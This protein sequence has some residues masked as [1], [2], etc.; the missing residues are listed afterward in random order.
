MPVLS[1]WWLAKDRADRG[2]SCRRLPRR[3]PAR[4]VDDATR[5]LLGAGPDLDRALTRGRHLDRDQLIAYIVEHLT[6]EP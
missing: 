2:R 5:S 3:P 1:E 4:S 6:A